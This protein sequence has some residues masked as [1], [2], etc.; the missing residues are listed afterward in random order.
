M[1]TYT[2]IHIYIYI[3]RCIHICVYINISTNTCTYACMPTYVCIS[4]HVCMSLHMY[5][6]IHSRKYMV[7]CMHVCV[8]QYVH[9]HACM[10]VAPTHEHMYTC[11]YRHMRMPMQIHKYVRLH[12]RPLLHMRTK[13]YEYIHT[14]MHTFLNC[15]THT[16]TKG[17]HMMRVVYCFAP[18]S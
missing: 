1:Y 10:Y 4:R 14:L 7:V 18:R 2:Y 12:L 15:P 6:F 11:N 9:T 16:C 3:D 13:E 5:S 17:K 8:S